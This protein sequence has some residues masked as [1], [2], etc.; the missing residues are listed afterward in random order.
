MKKKF[1]KK[2]M[3]PQLDTEVA[4]RI[5]NNILCEC[6]MA[7]ADDNFEIVLKRVEQRLNGRDMRGQK[8]DEK[9]I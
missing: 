9:S 3:G 1:K 6:G 5:L 8:S 2:E 4:E 7:P